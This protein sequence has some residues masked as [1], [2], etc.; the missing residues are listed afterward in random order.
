[1][2]DAYITTFNLLM[3]C[4]YAGH[5]AVL[6][7]CT[8]EDEAFIGM[9]ATLLDGVVVEK[10]G[11]VAA[12]A[13]VRQNTRIPCGEVHSNVTYYTEI[14]AIFN[15]QLIFHISN[16]RILL[17]DLRGKNPDL[18]LMENVHFIN[19]DDVHLSL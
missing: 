19:V 13:L 6:Q 11:M 16:A 12:G 2:Y 9:G 4:S 8:V 18:K 7:G 10:N 1:V 3:R 14:F 15:M 17:S 5:S